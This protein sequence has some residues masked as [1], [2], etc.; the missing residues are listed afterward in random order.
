MI[1]YQK[2]NNSLFVLLITPRHYYTTLPRNDTIGKVL[3]NSVS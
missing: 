3:T 2:H 1:R